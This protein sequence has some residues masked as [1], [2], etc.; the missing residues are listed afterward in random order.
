MYN[1]YTGTVMYCILICELKLKLKLKLV[2]SAT[3]YK[4]VLQY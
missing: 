4:L 1:V 3:A 2:R